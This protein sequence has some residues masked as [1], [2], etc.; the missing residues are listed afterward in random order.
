MTTEVKP[1]LLHEAKLDIELTNG[2]DGRGSKWFS[3]AKVRKQIEAK[4]I[5]WGHRRKPFDVP[6][7][8]EVTRIL[9]PNQRLW[10]ADSCGRGNCKELFDAMVVVG[11]FHDD[12]PKYIREV[13]FRQCD[14]SR[15][16]GPATIVRVF[17]AA[18][19]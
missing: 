12:G 16:L 9:G 5:A 7:T 13:R 14:F 4:L 11:F 15:D 18:K 6:V 3:S 8:V 17:E 2:N 19:E 1:K 10:D